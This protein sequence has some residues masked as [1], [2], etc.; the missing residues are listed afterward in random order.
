MHV[1]CMSD[2]IREV[3]IC[4]LPKH[5][6]QIQFK[7]YAFIRH[8]NTANVPYF[9]I[10]VRNVYNNYILYFQFQLIKISRK[11]FL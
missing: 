11:L 7:I 3:R 8:K 10:E 9:I 6:G 5:L 4:Q 2:N 1:A